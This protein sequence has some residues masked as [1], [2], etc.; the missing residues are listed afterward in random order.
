MQKLTDGPHFHKRIY[1][2]YRDADRYGEVEHNFSSKNI[3]YEYWEPR[4]QE[5]FEDGTNYH[6]LTEDFDYNE[7]YC[8]R[9]CKKNR[10]FRSPQISVV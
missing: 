6:D 4:N 10:E 8:C 7:V 1:L 2:S 5:Y 3:Q 9:K